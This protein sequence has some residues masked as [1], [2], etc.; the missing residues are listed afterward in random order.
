MGTFTKQSFE[1]LYQQPLP[2]GYFHRLAP[3]RYRSPDFARRLLPG[4]LAQLR[5]RTGRRRLKILDLACGYGINSALLK[6]GVDFATFARR[7]PLHPARGTEPPR[8]S[9]QATAAPT[10]T[11]AA[12]PH[13]VVTHE[14]VSRDA[15]FLRARA[16]DTELTVVGLDVSRP[17]TE[18]ALAAGLLD[19]AVNTDLERT[20]PTAA[21]RAVLAEADLVLATGA[22]SY[23]GIATL[24]RVL[25]LQ[26]TPPVVLGWPLYGQPT[27]AIARCLA[28]HRLTVTRPD[29][30]PRHQRYFADAREREA[31]HYSLRRLRLPFVGS[32]AETSLCVTSLLAHPAVG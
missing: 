12:T 10:L 6:F 1:S 20:D 25:A 21:D 15:A 27:E 31:Y 3:L 9:P 16:K 4:T 30:T 17:A 28:D 22:F 7:Y 18:Y 24:E 32:A 8:N 29:P 13:E 2:G 26:S 14:V 11:H 5:R 19:A 23:L